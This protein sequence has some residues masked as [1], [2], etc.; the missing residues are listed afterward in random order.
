MVIAT[1]TQRGTGSLHNNCTLDTSFYLMFDGYP[2]SAATNTITFGSGDPDGLYADKVLEVINGTGKGQ[3]GVIS[4]Y[5]SS[6]G[7]LHSYWDIVPDTTSR[8]IIH[9][10]SGLCPSQQ[11]NLHANSIWLDASDEASDDFYTGA[12]IKIF[13]CHVGTQIYKILAY[14]G[15]EK[16]ITT[17]ALTYPVGIHSKYVIY[18]EGGGTS[19]SSSTTITLD[20]QQSDYVVAG[21]YI[22]IISGM[23]QGQI[24][25][26]DAL[27]GDVATVSSWSI[28][29]TSCRYT[30][31]A[32]WGA[33][34][35][36][37]ILNYSTISSICMLDSTAGEAALL[38]S[39]QCV[40]M[41]GHAPIENI[42]EIT[43]KSQENHH[44][45]TVQATFLITKIVNTGMPCHG[46]LSTIMNSYKSGAPTYQVETPITHSSNIQ[47]VKSVITGKS[48]RDEYR[49]VGVDEFGNMRVN[50]SSPNDAFGNIPTVQPIQQF[51]AVFM[52]NSLNPALLKTELSST[53]VVS[54]TNN[55]ARVA[56]GTGAG[57][58]TMQSFKRTRYTPGI[59]IKIN[60]TAVFS[61]PCAIS[62]QY[63]GI[64][65]ASEGFLVGYNGL[66]FGILHRR[67]G[68]QE[69][70]KL[71]ITSVPSADTTVT[72]TLNGS[73]S[74]NISLL[75]TDSKQA[76][77]R[78]IAAT[79]FAAVGYGWDTYEEK[80]SVLFVR[81][82]ADVA[83]GT[84]SLNDVTSTTA[85]TFTAIISGTNPTE[86]WI[87]QMDWDIDRAYGEMGDLPSIN[88]QNGNVFEISYQWLGYGNITFKIENPLS[89]M[90]S[91]VHQIRYAS[92]SLVTSI[93]TPN[94]PLYAS[95]RKSNDS[96]SDNVYIDTSSMG[97]YSMGY[98]NPLLGTRLGITNTIFNSNK[99]MSANT[100][101]NL[102]LFRNKI[103]FNST[104]NVGEVYPLAIS[105]AMR[106]E[107][108][109]SG[110]ITF[111]A[112]PV[113]DDSN[114][115]NWTDRN[116]YVSS[117][118]YALDTVQVY[119]GNEL[120]SIPIQ[121]GTNVTIPVFGMEMYVL[122]GVTIS[123]AF[124]PFKAITTDVS[125]DTDVT[126][127]ISWAHR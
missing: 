85:G 26:I 113:V 40:D 90:L 71:T 80:E 74:G 121:N 117:V 55:I 38:I 45:S 100:Y 103:L 14:D 94:I 127:S 96:L 78:K 24:R 93:Q 126:F 118:S 50:I 57:I 51:E 92:S 65:D 81:R 39:R 59:A 23:G 28:P 95:V 44:T 52:N 47:Q 83:T 20:G 5:V 104:R 9:P 1:I 123:L 89:G 69:T 34:S 2:T 76:V 27:I 6:V 18:G 91:A 58:A 120:W 99:A 17:T 63:I 37:N 109:L 62:T 56:S 110:L 19:T 66:N 101:Y 60:F 33:A 48:M 88:F 15:S 102:L 21:Q 64:G 108:K 16:R 68:K 25:K 105:I 41:Q 12:Y 106:S 8:I 67:G 87:P 11:V 4:S 84:Y 53:G 70:R 13:N 115:I 97:V 79:S 75:S 49:N 43:S 31:F 119:G 3:C 107:L 111:M 61:R 114:G 82:T 125:N 10:R 116:Q 30:I 22:E 54:V 98:T 112:S 36:E 124:K 46:H 7:T 122:P 73:T 77:A 29:P 86:Y 35:L 32:G 42:S 72:V